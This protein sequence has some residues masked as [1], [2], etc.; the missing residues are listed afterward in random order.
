MKRRH[1][2]SVEEKSC[3]EPPCK[4]T[5]LNT[6]N[7]NSKPKKKAKR[8][9][10]YQLRAAGYSVGQFTLLNTARLEFKALFGMNK[11]TIAWSDVT[12]SQLQNAFSGNF[13][14]IFG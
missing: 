8:A 3:D 5:K 2:E 13:G 9:K 12:H 7:S 1:A 4:K 10:P 11:L 6:N 14:G